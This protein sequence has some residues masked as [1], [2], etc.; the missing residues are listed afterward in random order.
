MCVTSTNDPEIVTWLFSTLGPDIT[1]V[2]D[3]DNKATGSNAGKTTGGVAPNYGMRRLRFALRV[4]VGHASRLVRPQGWSYGHSQGWSHAPL[5]RLEL[6]PTLVAVSL[7]RISMRYIS[8][9]E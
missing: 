3:P 1:N 5:A 9:P 2:G 8:P 7:G 4:Q 6:E